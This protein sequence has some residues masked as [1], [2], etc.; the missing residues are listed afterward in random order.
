[1]ISYLDKM[2]LRP[3]EKRLVVVAALA[4]FGVLNFIFVVPRF[5]EWG[6]IEEQ[7]KASQVRLDKYGAEVNKQGLYKKELDRLRSIGHS[8][9]TE[10]Q[11]L[12]LSKTINLQAVVSG[13]SA[14]SIST[15]RRPSGGKTN[16]FFEEKTATVILTSSEQQLIDFLYLLGNGDSLIRAKSMNVQ[17]DNTKMR[18]SVTMNLVASYQRKPLSK[19]AAAT[20]GKVPGPE[21]PA[22]ITTGSPFKAPPPPPPRTN[23][24][25]RFNSF[26]AK[27]K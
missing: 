20:G 15:D 19:V 25:G 11:A 4:I 6:R 12:D 7:M 23:M 18:L 17:P 24:P 22:P 27:P 9:P 26:P 21:A 5:G 1:M 16:L 14:S 13:V 2:N 3:A 10:D 8:V